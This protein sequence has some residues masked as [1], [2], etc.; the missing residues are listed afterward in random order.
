[1]NGNSFSIE[2]FLGTW[3]L[4]PTESRYEF[5]TPPQQGQYTLAY[6]KGTLEVTMDWTDAA[7]KDFHMVYSAVPDGLDH[8]YSDSPTVDTICTTLVDARTLDTI[9]KKDGAVL[10]HGRRI[11]SEDGSRM[12]VVQSGNKPDGE[13]YENFAVYIKSERLG[14]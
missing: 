11:L 5:G 2:P 8:P 4:D 13:R 7:G 1:M 14:Q 10:A 12:T 6:A 9:S 3:V